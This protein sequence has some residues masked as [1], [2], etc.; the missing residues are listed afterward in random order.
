MQFRS[1][2]NLFIPKAGNQCFL[3][4]TRPLNG[5]FLFAFRFCKKRNHKSRQ[6]RRRNS[7]GAR[8]QRSRKN[9]EQ[10]FFADCLLGSVHKDITEARKRYRSPRSG[11]INKLIIYSARTEDNSEHNKG[12][13]YSCRR[14]LC[15]VYQYL[16]YNAYES[17]DKKRFKKNQQKT[18]PL[19]IFEIILCRFSII[20]PFANQ[21]LRAKAPRAYAP[22]IRPCRRREL[23]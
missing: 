14:H 2:K 16:S 22:H 13:E 10:A 15:H 6:H 17:A 21:I 19:P 20:I 23:F 9:T 8:T 18:F 4:N 7:C 1:R 5:Y 11:K 12:N 3:T